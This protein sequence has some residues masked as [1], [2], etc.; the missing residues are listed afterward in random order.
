[1][2][3]QG[4]NRGGRPAGARRAADQEHLFVAPGVAPGAPEP[5]ANDFAYVEPG[6]VTMANYRRHDVDDAMSARQPAFAPPP[7]FPRYARGTDAPQDAPYDAP[8]DDLSAP[9]PPQ[10]INYYQT[11]LPRDE[12]RYTPN[13][14]FASYQV[15]DEAREKPR[16]KRRRKRA[17]RRI[18]AAA[19]VLA[20]LGGG[21]YLGRDWLAAQWSRLAG[22]PA[23]PGQ[24]A[25]S[26]AAP[27]AEEKGYD[28]A[29]AQQPG[30]KAQEAIASITGDME[31]ETFAVTAHNIV[32]R[33]ARE[34]GRFDYYLFSDTGM[35]V[36]YFEDLAADG[37]AVCQNDCFYVAEPPYLVGG[38]GRALLNLQ[39]FAQ[40]TGSAPVLE[41]LQN[42][43]AIIRDAEGTL[44][45]YVT[46]EGELLS[47]LWFAKAF[48]FLG[49]STVAYVDSGN[50]EGGDERYSLYIIQ[51]SG[52]AQ[53]W[54][55]TADMEDVVGVACDMA[56]LRTGELI[57]LSL[58]DEPLCT[59]DLAL[60]YTDCGAVV[61]RDPQ[62][63]LFGLF[64]HGEQH[65]DF[66]YQA[67]EPVRCELEWRKRTEG[68]FTYCA[69]YGASFP[70]PLSHY[71]TLARGGQTERIALS[72]GSTYPVTLP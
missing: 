4:P 23:E 47:T 17:R 32:R 14:P 55:R 62:T 59:T 25:V 38:D 54:K 60:A 39:S 11:A 22:T 42:G 71:F 21:A 68:A 31:M 18:L 33:A 35:L 43:W 8:D 28:A 3:G 30:P 6:D 64:V 49:Q 5:P 44:Y 20:L 36:G 50:P 53:V 57:R 46:A 26:A 34:D 45:N 56:Y 52:S 24:Q 9:P 69:V 66:A 16:S 65:Y 37:F 29:P 63:G 51:Q 72:T 12:R 1:M 67:I 61:A 27:V 7:K 2:D 15:E 40:Y 70:Q 48:P 19:V 58:P 10:A 41:P 13:E